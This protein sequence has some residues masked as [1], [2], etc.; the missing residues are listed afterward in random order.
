MNECMG[1]GGR[2]GGKVP[3]DRLTAFDPMSVC[4]HACLPRQTRDSMTPSYWSNASCLPMYVHS[5]STGFTT[6]LLNLFTVHRSLRSRAGIIEADD[7]QLTT[8]F[9]VQPSFHH[10]HSTNWV[11]M[12]RYHRRRTTRWGVTARSPTMVTLH[13]TRFVVCR[14]WNDGW[15]VKT[16]VTWRSSASMRPAPEELSNGLEL[17]FT[18]RVTGTALPP[19]V[20]SKLGCQTVIDMFVVSSQTDVTIAVQIT[21]MTT[22]KMKA[23]LAVKSYIN[24]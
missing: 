24:M 4:F 9:T 15:T 2:G 19:D 6:G 13:D 17:L 16:V 11:Y 12:K 22:Y 14:W 21:T 18:S 10:G 23:V 7:R 8:V 20:E 5:I 3:L 1:G